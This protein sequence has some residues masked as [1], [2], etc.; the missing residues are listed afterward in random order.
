MLYNNEEEIKL[1]Q[2]LEDSLAQNIGLPKLNCG[3]VVIRNEK[4]WRENEKLIEYIWVVAFHHAVGR[5]GGIIN[6][7]Y[8]D[9]KFRDK[10]NPE[11]LLEA[12]FLM[13]SD[14]RIKNL[15]IEKT[16]EKEREEV[17][18]EFKNLN[19]MEA[20]KGITIDGIHYWIHLIFPNTDIVIKAGNPNHQTWKIWEEKLWN[21]WNTLSINSKDN[22]KIKIFDF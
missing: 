22:E 2:R 10:S 12:I 18:D 13:K 6:V 3:N 17:F 11:E 15:Y 8:N 7:K 21:K 5:S 4:G 20:N 9:S 1:Y 19:L 16:E 14:G